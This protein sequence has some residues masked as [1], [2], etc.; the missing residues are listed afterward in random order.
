MR[1]ILPLLLAALLAACEPPSY[2]LAIRNVTAVDAENGIRERVT[3]LIRGD[4]IADVIPAD[5]RHRALRVLD[6]QGGFLIPGLW[7]MHVHLAYEGPEPEVAA[8]QFLD[9]GITSVRDTGGLLEEI[10]P[11]VDRLEA[12]PE[13][14]RVFFAGPLLDGEDVVYDGQQRPAI[15]VGNPN[16][17]SARAQVQ[18][19]A[20]AGVDFVKVYELVSPEVFAALVEAARELDLPVAAHV[21]LSMTAREAGPHVDSMEHL[22]NVELDCAANGDS[23]LTVRQDLLRNEDGI[24]GHTLR[25]QIHGAQRIPAIDAFE[26]DRCDLVVQALMQTIQVPTLR[27][28]TLSMAAPF[29][30]PDWER[31]LSGLPRELAESMRASAGRM[32]ASTS[33]VN[34]TFARWSMQLTG[35]MHEAGVPIGAGTDTPIGLALPGYSLHNELDLLVQAG[36]S[37]RD[38]LWAGTR[39]APRFLGLEDRFGT[40]DPGMAA[41]LV[42]LRANPLDDI[43]NTRQIRAVVSRGVVVRSR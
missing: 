36:L 10:L 42:L 31:A 34:T 16:P 22:R 7:D 9:W 26:P 30:R 4:E 20:A 29:T 25:G 38:A 21:P 12:L 27:L 41:D 19:L 8:A 37:N 32:Q 28:N 23:L 35:M 11:I 24:P 14:P 3:V 43:N 1:R 13:A 18:A 39:A 40:I 2:D 5:S 15:G 33:P 17:D 6:G